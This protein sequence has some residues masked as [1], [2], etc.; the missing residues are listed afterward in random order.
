MPLYDFHMH[1]FFSDGAL[2]PMELI[3]RAHVNGL[4]HRGSGRKGE[5]RL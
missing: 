3:R 2:L 1:S 5:A 4:E